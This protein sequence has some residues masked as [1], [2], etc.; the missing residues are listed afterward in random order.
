GEVEPAVLDG[1]VRGVAAT[2]AGVEIGT[3]A[4]EL[5]IGFERLVDQLEFATAM[6]ERIAMESLAHSLSPVVL[7]VLAGSSR[8]MQR[9][10]APSARLARQ[11]R[12][13]SDPG[14]M[15]GVAIR[16]L[17]SSG[18]RTDPSGRPRSGRRGRAQS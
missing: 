5:E 8:L 9:S 14:V 10:L 7:V 18:R 15:N 12:T 11:A 6:R 2:I 17:P 13:N 3:T 16:R 4:D 1:P